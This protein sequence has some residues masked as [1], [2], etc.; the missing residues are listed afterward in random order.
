MSRPDP[1]LGSGEDKRRWHGDVDRAGD[2]RAQG[3]E[4]LAQRLIEWFKLR[5]WCPAKWMWMV[6]VHGSWQ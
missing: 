5:R 2:R 4:H 3:I 6:A 1:W